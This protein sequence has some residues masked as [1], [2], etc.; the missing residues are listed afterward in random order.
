MSKKL[1]SAKSNEDGEQNEISDCKLMQEVSDISV[2][3]IIAEH[4]VNAKK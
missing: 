1:T 3:K 2:Y 4:E